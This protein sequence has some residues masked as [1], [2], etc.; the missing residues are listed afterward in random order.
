MFKKKGWELGE[1]VQM[2]LI[3]LSKLY[4][5][6]VGHPIH[7]GASGKQYSICI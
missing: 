1:V 3:Q 4:H 6:N 2:K 7:P 5:Q